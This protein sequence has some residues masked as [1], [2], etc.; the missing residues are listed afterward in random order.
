LDSVSPHEFHKIFDRT[1]MDVD[2]RGATS[3]VRIDNYLKI[4]RQQSKDRAKQAKQVIGREWY[5]IKTHKIDNLLE[6]GFADR[7]IYEALRDR[8]GMINLTLNYGRREALERIRAQKR[9]Q[10][11]ARL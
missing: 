1:S 8:K 4:A 7:A 3:A 9:A 11:R 10:I 5:G 2:L 6:H